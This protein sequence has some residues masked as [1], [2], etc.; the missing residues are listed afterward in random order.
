[1]E[2]ISPLQFLTSRSVMIFF[3]QMGF[4]KVDGESGSSVDSTLSKSK[5]EGSTKT[6]TRRRRHATPRE[7]A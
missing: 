7:G 2:L 6:S 1:M 3:E 5:L 4:A